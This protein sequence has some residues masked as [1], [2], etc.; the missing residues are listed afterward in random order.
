M[1][2][3]FHA[4]LRIAATVLALLLTACA[5][6]SLETMRNPVPVIV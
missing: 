3:G 4:F 5:S 2:T 6:T 1:T